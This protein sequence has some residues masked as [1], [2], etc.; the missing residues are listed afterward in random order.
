MI[1]HKTQQNLSKKTITLPTYNT[2]I[3]NDFES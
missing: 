3:E 2:T 1:T